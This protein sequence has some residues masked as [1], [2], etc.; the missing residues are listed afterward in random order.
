ML[1]R[2]PGSMAI[3]RILN[4]LRF[5]VK[6]IDPSTGGEREGRQAGR[7][8]AAATARACRHCSVQLMAASP[9]F[10]GCTMAR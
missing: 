7:W 8:V 1:A 4:T 2:P 6:E 9:A 5:R 3:G 10:I